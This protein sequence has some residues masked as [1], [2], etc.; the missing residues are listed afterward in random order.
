MDVLDWNEI[1]M[2]SGCI[3]LI[4]AAVH[5]SMTLSPGLVESPWL[6]TAWA[7]SLDNGVIIELWDSLAGGGLAQAAPDALIQKTSPIELSWSLTE[8]VSLVVLPLFSLVVLIAV[9]MTTIGIR[10]DAVASGDAPSSNRHGVLPGENEKRDG[11]GGVTEMGSE[12]GTGELQRRMTMIMR[13]NQKQELMCRLVS[14][15]AHNINNLLTG[16]IGNINLAELKCSIETEEYLKRARLSA[17]RAAEIVNGLL[18]FSR[19]SSVKF[20]RINLND[21]VLDTYQLLRGVFES[22]INLCVEPSH[23]PLFVYAD[24]RL[25]QTVLMNVCVNSR[26]AIRAVMDSDAPAALR[27]NASWYALIRTSIVSTR[28]SLDESV[29]KY[30]LITVNDNGVGMT[31]AQKDRVFDPF[32]TTKDDVGKGMGLAVA[33]GIVLQHEGWI[34]FTSQFGEGSTFNIYLPLN[35]NDEVNSREW[36]RDESPMRDSV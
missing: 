10:R 16:V 33:Y 3:L 27:K 15:M 34:D 24:P 1:M 12:D 14:G 7:H 22:R 30:A 25:V 21:L 19:E 23:S 13:Q 31:D 11:A 5:G 20:E 35:E 4:F 6:M 29:R 8:V 18:T 36:S 9:L 17:D 26:D 2:K 28:K 32:F